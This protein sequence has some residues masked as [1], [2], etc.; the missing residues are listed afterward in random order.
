MI[1]QEIIDEYNLRNVVEDDGWCY[2]EIRKALYGLKEAAYLSNIE[3][4]RVL[5]EEGYV[6]SEFTPGLFTHKTRDIL[7]SLHKL[8]WHAIHQKIRCRALGREC[9]KQI[10]HDSIIGARLLPWN[11]S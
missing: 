6:P 7:Y 10:P 3:L 1:P 9:K 4:K 2:S 5:A 11:D 8:F